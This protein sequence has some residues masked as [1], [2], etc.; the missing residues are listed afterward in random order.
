MFT[1]ENRR[2]ERSRDPKSFASGSEYTLTK[3]SSCPNH[4]D[5]VKEVSIVATATQIPAQIP[6][7]A[8][9]VKV[10]DVLTKLR[11]AGYERQL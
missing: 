4:R 9:S 2:T 7:E 8:Q 10:M 3:P 6:T 5:H 1:P 11:D